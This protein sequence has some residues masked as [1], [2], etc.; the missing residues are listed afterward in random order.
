MNFLLGLFIGA[1]VGY[2]AA[3]VVSPHAFPVYATGLLLG[4]IGVLWLTLW[5]KEEQGE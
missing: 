2:S 1:L 4:G 5:I 3:V